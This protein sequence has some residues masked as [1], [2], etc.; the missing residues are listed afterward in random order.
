MAISGVFNYE[1]KEWKFSQALELTLLS[2][3]SGSGL[4]M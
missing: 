3:Y 4:G 1:V 2:H